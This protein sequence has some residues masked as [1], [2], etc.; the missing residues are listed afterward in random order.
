MYPKLGRNSPCPCNSGKKYKQCCSERNTETHFNPNDSFAEQELRKGVL[1]HSQGD[2]S[3]AEKCYRNILLIDPNHA[4]AHH[5]LGTL[6]AG[7][8]PPSP[9]AISHFEAALSFDSKKL[10]FWQNYL[11]TL[12][13]MGQYTKM[14]RKILLAS[15]AGINLSDLHKT[16][17]PILDIHTTN[18]RE[19]ERWT[20]LIDFARAGISI[21][22]YNSDYWKNLGLAYYHLNEF[23]GAAQA[24][25]KV[26][27][28]RPTDDDCWNFLSAIYIN[29]H[30]FHQA[31]AA[32]EKCLELNPNHLNGLCNAA[33]IAMEQGRIDDTQQFVKKISVLNNGNPELYLALSKLAYKQKNLE[34]AIT[35]IRNGIESLKASPISAPKKE[36]FV[37]QEDAAR[38]LFEAN[39]ILSNHDI[40]FFLIAGTLLG[41]MRD[42]DLLKNDKDMDIGVVGNHQKEKII[43]VLIESNKFRLHPNTPAK[44]PQWDW[45][46]GFIHK[47]TNA[48]VDI[49]FYREEA[50][51]LISGFY[52]TPY[53]ITSRVRAFSLGSIVWKNTE[54]KIPFPAEQYF[55]DVYGAGWKTP[56]QGFDT[57]ISHKSQMIE[58]K[59]ARFYL[60]H[61]RLF[62]LIKIGN[63][64]KAKSCCNQLQL[65]TPDLYL[66]NLNDWLTQKSN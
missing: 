18:F 13:H 36:T 28:L 35:S 19:S 45:N 24:I 54:W 9:Q 64:K 7:R 49:F 5:N 52:N 21:D 57:I 33:S 44:S 3:K 29:T 1:F 56:D 39:S 55:E 40:P 32:V 42:G 62:D 22:A 59:P 63:W 48:V 17:N 58:T 47:A 14:A 34:L 38:A 26:L 30:N 60:G 6:L 37:S 8:N 15:D 46:I 11:L 10:L 53:P 51:S 31:K 41:I 20:G 43:S 27:S 16:L 25:E 66:E 61:L 12:N 2:L 65:A 50:E 23:D 4:Q